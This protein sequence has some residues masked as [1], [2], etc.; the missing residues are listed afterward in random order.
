MN[1]VITGASSGIG[2]E[3]SRYFCKNGHTVLGIARTSKGLN[4][5][6]NEYPDSFVPFQW[7]ICSDDYALLDVQLNKFDAI[8]ILI[9]NAGLLLNSPL[10]QITPG[11]MRD[12]Y[13]TNVFAPFR[14]IQR[15]IPKMTS[16]EWAHIV[17]IGSMGGYQ[18]SVKFAGLSAYSSSKAALAGLTE[19]LAEEFKDMKVKVNCLALGSVRTPMLEAAFPGFTPHTEAYDMAEYIAEFSLRGWRYYNGKVLPVS[20]STP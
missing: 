9:N 1:I 10:A 15:I 16:L 8:S 7:D 5:L 3:L 11:Q 20:G 13:E 17:N 12:V 19:C 14:L 4:L 18:G 6:Y 2:Y